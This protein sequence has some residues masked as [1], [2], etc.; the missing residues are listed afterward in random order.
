MI[1]KVRETINWIIFKELEKWTVP[2][3]QT[4][5][6][7]Q[8][9]WTTWKPY[10][11]INQLLLQIRKQQ[12]DLNSNRWCTFKMINNLWWKV[13]KWTKWTPVIY[14]KL[15]EKNSK[16]DKKEYIP[17][18]KMYWVFNLDQTNLKNTIWFNSEIVTMN[19]AECLRE[20]FLDK[21]QVIY[22]PQPH[23]NPQ[24]DVI[25]MP[26][27][28]DF[29]SE[30]EYRVTLFHEWIHA[31]WSKDRLN[32]KEVSWSNI[33]FWSCDYSKEELVAEFWASYLAGFAG[34]ENSTIENSS[35]YIEQWLKKIS[36]DKNVLIK[37]AGDGWKAS[38]YILSKRNGS[39]P[40][41][42]IP[43]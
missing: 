36:E 25:W 7:I 18:L 39:T 2:W 20:N 24:R 9:S 14:Y 4:W 15:L 21:P 11:G 38:E 19:S 27:K 10:W 13:N 41:L 6:T 17:I 33:N 1:N 26:K 28:S 42:I 35:A 23:Y 8:L 31:T 22:D 5:N 29:I 16:D 34:I 12:K 40:N 32:R 30:S 37:A 3:K 43:V